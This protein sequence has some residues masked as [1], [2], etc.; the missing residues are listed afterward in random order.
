MDSSTPSLP[1][2]HQALKDSKLAH[3][4]GSAT[5]LHNRYQILRILG[6][7]G[8]GVTF[9]ARDATL[10]SAPL[11][12]VK[13]LCPKVSTPIAL[14]RAKR[15]F[16][17]EAKTLS[18]VGNHSQIPLLLDYFT[19][20]DEFYLVQDYV[21]G[22]TLTR[23]VRRS[24][25]FSET[26]VKQF[27][28]E[29][30]PVLQYIHNRGVIH[31]DIKPPNIIRCRDDGRLVLID[32]GA[33]KDQLNTA[34]MELS[35]AASTQFIGTVGFAPPEQV[36]LRPTFASDIYALGVTCLY[37]LTGKT[38]LEFE[39]DAETGE[40]D[41]HSLASVTPHFAAILD[42]MMKVS[43]SERYQRVDEILR[44]LDLESHLDQL[45]QCMH[46]LPHPTLANRV[47]ASQTY[48]DEV[49]S[50]GGGGRGVA[51]GYH[52][53]TQRAAAQIRSWRSRLQEREK[54]RSRSS[55]AYP[56]MPM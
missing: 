33:V 55:F 51:N 16:W 47:A 8:F 11:C 39:Y 20:D 50:M 42:K 37:L 28:R 10:P 32:F 25:L 36:A 4:C 3:L 1:N 48:A 49:P 38:P 35:K 17:Q 45:S 9:L 34:E 30:L 46:T 12:V 44:A 21:R 6:R 26:A 7:G 52:T 54:R 43:L 40:I 53:P 14:E 23:E 13:Q 2:M 31:R 41:W 27:L 18:Q 5:L 56:T 29:L 24:G 22:T 15:R 19:I